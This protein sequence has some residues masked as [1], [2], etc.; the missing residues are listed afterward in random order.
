M[1]FS[2]YQQEPH[3]ALV[4]YEDLRESNEGAAIQGSA[5]GLSYVRPQPDLRLSAE[6]EVRSTA[7][8]HPDS[9]LVEAPRLSL[10]AW[11]SAT[12]VDHADAA[13]GVCV[14]GDL[15]AT[16]WVA[17]ATA[18][19]PPASATVIATTKPEVGTAALVDPDAISVG[20]PGLSLDAWR[21]AAL[22]DHADATAGV[23]VAE[24][25]FAIV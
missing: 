21:S 7:A 3:P 25:S 20:S 24:V 17:S 4:R 8:I 9:T 22:I 1:A 10:D 18:R 6:L 23:C 5:P 19:I 14:A 11:R 16:G 12:L 2:R 15:P 13:A